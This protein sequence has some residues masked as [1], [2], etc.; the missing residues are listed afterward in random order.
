[1]GRSGGITSLV[2]VKIHIESN[3]ANNGLRNV[4]QCMASIYL[5]LGYRRLDPH[6][7]YFQTWYHG[8]LPSAGH[9]ASKVLARDSSFFEM[10]V[11]SQHALHVSI[12]RLPT[13]SSSLRLALLL[14]WLR[15]DRAAFVR[16]R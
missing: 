16:R 9:L 5:F 7:N 6:S 3:V 10:R 13:L 1:M 4:T 12:C 14:Y 2:C 11:I 8:C 15:F